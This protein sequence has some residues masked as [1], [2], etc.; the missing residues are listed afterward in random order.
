MTRFRWRMVAIGISATVVLPTAACSVG[1]ESLP[2]PTPGVGG[3]SYTLHA[4][5]ANAL[6]LPTKAKV[7][8]AGADVGEVESMRARDYT[9]VVTMRIMSGVVLPVGTSAELRSAT[10]LGD[11]FVAVAPP[12][13]TASD[14]AVLRDGDTIPLASTSAAAT[15]EEL[16]TTSSLL[17]NGGAIRDLTKIVNGLGA[18]V[19]DQGERIADLINQSTRLVQSLAARSGE[20]S[21]ALVQTDRLTAT[22]AAQQST[23][24]DVV[25]AAGPAL[26]VL[27][28]NT[29]QILGLVSEVAR[30]SRQIAKFPSVNGTDTRSM[31]A[32]INRIA[33]E[34]NDAAISPDGSLDAVNKILGPI[35]KITDATSAHV[36]VDLQDL[37]IGALPDPRHPGD[38]G[39]QLPDATDWAAFVGSLTYTLLRLQDRV[40]GPGR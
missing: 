37:A 39:S 1:L 13:P 31:V 33:G 15:I 24:D 5:F 6:N 32:D 16:L 23:I 27:S 18:A 20:I 30:I 38:P 10:P 9:A 22:L 28:A 25:S 7:K 17:V 19:G 12:P 29:Q 36:N 21:D 11:V 4:T 26:G 14:T 34:L 35:I 8:L 2:L 40:I 3:N